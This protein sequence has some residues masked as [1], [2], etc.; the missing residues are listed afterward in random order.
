MNKRF[1]PDEQAAVA[2][3]AS[4]ET[5]RAAMV[6]A[7]YGPDFERC[8]LLCETADRHATGIAHHYILVEGRDVALFK[9]LETPK[10]TV[11]DERDLL[12]KWL[13]CFD[14]PLSGFKRRIWLSF[15]TKPLRGWHVQQLRRIAIASHVSEN[16]LVFCDSDVAFLRPFDFGAFR[17]DGKTRLFRRDHAL[18]EEGLDGHIQQRIWS[19]NAGKL[20]GL[21]AKNDVGHDYITTLIAWDR[22]TVVAMCR[23]IEAINHRHWVAAIGSERKFSECLIYGRYVDEV[24]EGK[25]HFHDA[26]EFC[27]VL[28]Y[29]TALSDDKFRAFVAAMSPEQVAIGMQSFIGTDVSRIRRLV[30]VE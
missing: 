19:T 4:R 8:R 22:E 5:P 10:R 24:I 7:S 20:L 15:R 26:R 14:D 13:K 3:M 25:G 28:W 1:T 27:N 11:V 23:H 12:P 6:T 16:T 30:L 18:R 2:G 9:Q 17:K 29:G 21:Q